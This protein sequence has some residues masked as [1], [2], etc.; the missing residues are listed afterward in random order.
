M[1]RFRRH[2][3]PC[4]MRTTTSGENKHSGRHFEVSL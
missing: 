1:Y 4:L 3:R 2:S